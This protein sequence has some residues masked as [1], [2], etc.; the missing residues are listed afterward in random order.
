MLTKLTPHLAGLNTLANHGY[1]P[2]NGI[3][4]LG[5]IVTAV[6]EGFNMEYTLATGLASFGML[7]RGNLRLNKLSIGGPTKEIPALPGNIDGLPGGL[8]THGR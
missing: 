2:R 7:A 3:V 5:D 8:A 4:S 6:Q 1:L